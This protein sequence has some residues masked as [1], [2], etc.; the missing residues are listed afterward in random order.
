[1][2]V[3]EIALW[4]CRRSGSGRVWVFWLD[5]DP[6][7]FII[8]N[9]N[10]PP[11]FY[12]IKEREKKTLVQFLLCTCN[13]SPGSGSLFLWRQD[14]DPSNIDPDLQHLWVKFWANLT[15]IFI[16]TRLLCNNTPCLVINH[17]FL[18]L[19]NN[20]RRGTWLRIRWLKKN[21]LPLPSTLFL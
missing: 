10:I 19:D 1:M 11:F 15:R 6:C 13:I 20:R 5:P 18:S 9:F 21:I 7:F 4:R 8:S 14:P 3:Y 16:R 2:R 12:Q 17:F